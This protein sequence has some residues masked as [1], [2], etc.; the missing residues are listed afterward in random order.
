MNCYE[1]LKNNLKYLREQNAETQ[2][3]VAEKTKISRTNLAR[4]ETGENV[5]PLDVLIV[6]ANYYEITIDD[7]I[8]NE[9]K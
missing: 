2:R 7:L 1:N 8:Y 9:M 4:Y 5:P 3:Q 6:L